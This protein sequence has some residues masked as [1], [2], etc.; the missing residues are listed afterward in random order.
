[1]EKDPRLI[2]DVD[3]LGGE[4]WSFDDQ[5]TEEHV[6]ALLN[7]HGPTD[8]K[9]LTPL[10]A[11]LTLHKI[12][13]GV[14]LEGT[15]HLTVTTP[16]ARCLAPAPLELD[17]HVGLTLFPP[18]ED[19]RPRTAPEPVASATQAARKTK[20]RKAPRVS[21]EDAPLSGRVDD[22]V[23][24]GTY[25]GGV[26]DVA[27]ILRELALLEVPMTVHCRPDCKGLCPTCGADL[28]QGP[29]PCPPPPPDP[30]LVAL[31]HIKLD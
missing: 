14:R 1:M 11:T 7:Q 20:K 21:A 27:E 30:R 17:L 13:Q 8:L 12:P 15:A 4:G 24:T 6:T 9:T 3:S 5:L 29:C 31:A 23:E 26:V 18:G 22:D 16:C 25:E 10:R 2:V 19:V 28:N